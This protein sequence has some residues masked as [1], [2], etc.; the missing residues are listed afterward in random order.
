MSPQGCGSA[1]DSKVS[2]QCDIGLELDLLKKSLCGLEDRM[3]CIETQYMKFDART[4]KMDDDVCCNA[5]VR[6]VCL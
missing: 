6:V 5:C 2:M 4:G 1:D 3:T